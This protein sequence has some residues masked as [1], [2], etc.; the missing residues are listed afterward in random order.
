MK[1]GMRPRKPGIKYIKGVERPHTWLVGEDEYKHQMYLPWL[2]ARSQ[3]KFRQEE[4]TLTFEEYYSLWNGKW[5]Q[6][7]RDTD[8]LCMTRHDWTGAWALDNVYICTRKEHCQRQGLARR[9]E[10]RRTRGMDI[11]K[12]K[13]KEKKN[14]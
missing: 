14:G 12:R 4:F 2:K 8:E 13:S 5:E 3:A 10:K 11:H 9:G 6:R 1:G 7:G